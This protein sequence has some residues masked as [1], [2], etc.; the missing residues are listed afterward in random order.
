[1]RGLELLTSCMRSKNTYSVEIE[2]YLQFGYAP[3]GSTPLR[4]TI[5][6]VAGGW[7]IP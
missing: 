5:G 6:P 1:M 2:Q 3:K 7:L 4:E